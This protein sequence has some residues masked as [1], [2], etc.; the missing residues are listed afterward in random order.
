[1]RAPHGLRQAFIT[2]GVPPVGLDIDEVYRATYLRIM[3]RVERYYQR[4]PADRQRVRDIVAEL[5]AEDVRLPGGD[6]LTAR[7]FRQ[8]GNLLGMSD[9]A[10]RLHHLLE[11]PLSS[12]AFRY[13]MELMPMPFAR[14]PIYAVLHEACYADG[15]V[16]RWSADRVRPEAYET[17]A[18]LLTGE[19]VFPWMFADYGGLAVF[20]AAAE[21][22]AEQSWPRLYDADTLQNHEVPVAAAIYVEDP[23]VESRF[24]IETASLVRG[25]RTWVTNEY[26]HN[27]LRADGARILDRLIGLATGRA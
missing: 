4:Y 3:D 21:L 26:D 16:T 7:R 10:E 20:R 24:S 1:S 18:S 27:G 19:H 23:Y 22:L 14:N 5:T 17:D 12:R 8:A 9:G 15:G 25:M 13:D 6:R 11:L 2:G